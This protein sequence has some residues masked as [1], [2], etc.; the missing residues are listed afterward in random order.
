MCHKENVII[1]EET[2]N[3]FNSQSLRFLFFYKK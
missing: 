1:I 2:N 3:T